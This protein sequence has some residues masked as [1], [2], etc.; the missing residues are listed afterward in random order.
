MSKKVKCCECASFLGWALP[1]RVDKDN[2]EYAKR[3]FEL[4]STTGVCG[5]SMKT[6]QMAHEQY[7]KRF[8][9][10]KYLEQESEPFKQEILNLKNAIAEYEK[11]NFVEV[12]ESWK[13]LFMKRF[14]E[15]KY[16]ER[17]TERYDVTPDGE[18]DVWVK[19]HDYISA[20]RKLCDYEDLEEQGLLVRLPCKV[21]DTV[22]DNDF[23][24]P[25]SYEI[26]AFSYGYCDSYVEPDI[27][28]EDQIIFYYE[29]YSGSIAGAFTMSEIGKTVFLT[30]EE[31]GMMEKKEVK[32]DVFGKYRKCSY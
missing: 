31:A 13:V 25:K 30:R 17:L 9:K 4:A 6:K 29:N 16:M 28:I 2:Y 5:Y 24:Y 26:K 10:N 14:Q 32:S 27:D 19:Q 8:E 11:E 12:D 7:C 22:W 3:V 1:E 23:G 21:G 20:A 15:V 18:S